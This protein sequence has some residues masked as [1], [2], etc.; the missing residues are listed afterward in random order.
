MVGWRMVLP[1]SGESRCL[2]YLLAE[3]F[4]DACVCV[5]VQPDFPLN[6]FIL[7]TA[8]SIKWEH[9]FSN[10]FP[11]ATWLFTFSVPI[12]SKV[13]RRV[14]E[15]TYILQDSCGHLQQTSR[16]DIITD[17]DDVTSKIDEGSHVVALHPSYYYR[18]VYFHF[19]FTQLKLAF[20]Y[21]NNFLL[22][23]FHSVYT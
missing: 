17:N 12:C 6:S 8:L 5:F 21:R 7:L 15:R 23:F 4:Q 11:F 2:L 14:S 19:Y 10:K 9:K 3:A 16:D 20:S 1:V 13:Q 18:W 22:F